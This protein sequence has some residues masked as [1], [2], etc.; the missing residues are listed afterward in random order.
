[1][2]GGKLGVIASLGARQEGCQSRARPFDFLAMAR[3]RDERGF[4]SAEILACERD[5]RGFQRVQPLAGFGGDGEGP[6][7][8]VWLRRQEI[9]LVEN[10]DHCL[11]PGVTPLTLSLSPWERGRQNF[12]CG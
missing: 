2:L 11:A 5:E 3:P 10:C 1:M 4:G 9:G 7:T 12:R 8:A 6:R